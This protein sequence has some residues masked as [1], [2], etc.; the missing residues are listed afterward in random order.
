MGLLCFE[1]TD[2]SA[3]HLVLDLH[4]VEDCVDRY[5]VRSDGQDDH[6]EC[7]AEELHDD[8]P[9]DGDA[10]NHKLVN[11]QRVSRLKENKRQVKG[12]SR[13]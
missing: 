5:K 9:S 13:R 12:A 4:T 7:E 1:R 8:I 10:K 3:S 11:E 2:S 6:G